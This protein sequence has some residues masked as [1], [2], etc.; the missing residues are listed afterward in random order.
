MMVHLKIFNLFSGNTNYDYQ[1]LRNFFLN[2]VKI[3]FFQKR[4]HAFSI[5]I[6]GQTLPVYFPPQNSINSINSHCP[7]TT[8]FS[9]CS[10]YDSI[11]KQPE[12]EQTVVVGR[13]GCCVAE[14][15]FGKARFSKPIS[16]K[17]SRRGRRLEGSA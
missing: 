3:T 16:L 5:I 11:K 10:V 15:P 8:K 7:R 1:S 12:S 6:L 13:A 9:R 4:L 17:P 14:A 2:N